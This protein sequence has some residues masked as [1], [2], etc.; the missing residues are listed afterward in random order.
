MKDINEDPLG[1][2]R[3][4]FII[5]ISDVHHPNFAQIRWSCASSKMKHR[6]SKLVIMDASSKL[7]IHSYKPYCHTFSVLTCVNQFWPWALLA[8]CDS[9]RWLWSTQ[10]CSGRNP[11]DEHLGTDHR[12]SRGAIAV[13]ECYEVVGGDRY[14]WLRFKLV[15]IHFCICIY[16][17]ISV[18]VV[19]NVSVCM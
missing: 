5:F 18:C 2:L 12:A 3:R 1:I 9:N 10:F 14:V 4:S 13:S 11:E 16:I 7:K 15:L 8:F 17:Y 19:W 6:P